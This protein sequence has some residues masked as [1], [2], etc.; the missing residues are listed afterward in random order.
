MMQAYLISDDEAMAGRARQ[1]LLRHGVECSAANL[2]S[3]DQ[4]SFLLAGAQETDLI[5][6]VLR[7]APERALR[8]IEQVRAGK[9]KVHVLAIGPTADPKLVLRTL[10]AGANDFVDEAELDAELEAAL[11]RWASARPDG[12]EE[13][14]LIA[15]LA[16]SGGSGSST[17]A[18]NMAT[19]LAKEHKAAALI[20]LK[21]QSGDL[22]A[23][24]DLKPT[25]T[26]ADLCRS[27]G[28]VDRVLFDRTLVKHT[29]GV[30][31]LASPQM[32]ADASYVNAEGVRHALALAR[33]TF[34]YVVADLDHTFGDEQVTVLRQAD[35]VLLVFR[36]DFASLRNTRRA[37]EYLQTL[38]VPIERI[39][40]VVN[41]HGQPK[42]VPAAKA[43]EALGT[44]IAHYVPDDAKSVNRA[45]NNGVPVVLDA[46][47]AKVSRSV[48]KL[49]FSVN[50]V[51]K[52]S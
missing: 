9:G 2:A 12:D 10:R 20:D 15:V 6:L 24:L 48:A 3:L 31:L 35:V 1:V 7:P 50:G 37:I 23:L 33:Q 45:N 41:R 46:P 40:L 30:S 8:L 11:E 5:V 52:P 44:K 38:G 51:H 34:P 42:E 25:Y 29:S 28:R 21:L 49:A 39:R 19:V 26:L 22:A 47:S 16:P 14:R 43:E 17:L 4:A 32:L 13:G 36:L 18:A 27:A